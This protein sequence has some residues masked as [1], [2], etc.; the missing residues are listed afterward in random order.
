MYVEG[1]KVNV[2][3]WLATV[4]RLRYKDFQLAGRPTRIQAH[5]E[6]SD[7]GPE[8]T[9]LYETG[10]VKDF[11]SN[12]DKRGVLAWWRMAMGYKDRL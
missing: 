6:E 5:F 1:P 12:M 4:K 8:Q 2:E 7:D 10:S 9:G 3:N 11:A